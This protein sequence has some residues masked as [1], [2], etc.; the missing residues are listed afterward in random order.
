MWYLSDPLVFLVITIS[1]DKYP[2]KRYLVLLIQAELDESP[3]FLN[4]S[5][6]RAH[7]CGESDVSVVPDMFLSVC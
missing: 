5:F 6:F 7:D 4:V 2:V 3:S 1:V